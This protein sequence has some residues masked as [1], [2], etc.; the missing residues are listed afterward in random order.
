MVKLV[1]ATT[2]RRMEG[3]GMRPRAAP[4]PG[5]EVEMRRVA[6]RRGTVAP[7]LEASKD[8][9]CESTLS[10]PSHVRIAANCA[11]LKRRGVVVLAASR[12]VRASSSRGGSE[13][14]FFLSTG[15]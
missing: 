7:V 5:W 8:A 15:W 4:G 9:D 1:E 6:S 11:C 13:S 3:S 10:Q 12:S 2:E 14:V